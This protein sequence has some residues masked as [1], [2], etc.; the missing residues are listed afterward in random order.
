MDLR[1]IGYVVAVADEGGFSA[2]ARAL[3]VAQPSVSQAVAQLERE[4]GVRLFDRIGRQ[5]NVTAAGAA[6]IA[7]ARRMLLEARSAREA[8]ASVQGLGAGHLDL[9]ALPTVATDPLAGLIGTFRLAH[10]GVRIHV[11]E[12]DT[13]DEAWSMVASGAAE[14]ALAEVPPDGSE[15]VADAVFTQELVVIAPPGG[16]STRR[17]VDAA[18]AAGGQRAN[19]AVE[20]AQRESII[21]LVL[22]G[23]GVAVL[24]EATARRAAAAGAGVARLRPP[25][26][27]TLCVVHRA[28]GLSPAAAAFVDLARLSLGGT[29][30][31]A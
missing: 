11:A 14:L 10:P 28:G 27:R 4:L 25:L 5:V 18:L 20:T 31:F 24:P 26:V 2:A 29:A 7:P 8:V 16:T 30:P 21:P 19:V 13:A 15:L 3:G 22:A 6:L 17:L 12:P 9:V 23:A 1:Q